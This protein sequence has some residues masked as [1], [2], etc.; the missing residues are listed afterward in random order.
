MLKVIGQK[1]NI[2][3][4]ATW[5]KIPNFIICEGERGSGRKTLLRHIAEQFGADSIVVG[6]KVDDIRDIILDANSLFNER[7]YVLEGDDM[8]PGA[9]NSLLK[10]T[11]EPP[12]RCHLALLVSSTQQTL[13][14]LVSR[15]HVM[16]TAPYTVE[17][18]I[19]YLKSRIELKDERHYVDYANMVSNLG[20]FEPLLAH[21]IS[22]VYQKVNDLYESI[23]IASES[24]ALNIANWLKLK[25]TGNDDAMEP[26]M[27]FKA[28]SNIGSIMTVR[29]AEVMSWDE[30]Y[31]HNRLLMSISKCIRK[32]QMKSTSKEITVNSWIREVKSI[33]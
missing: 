2:G 3:K 9:K 26:L 24:N 17:E 15:A 21:G 29:E 5:E 22:D 23:D 7:I 30:A 13:P 6:N 12:K 33:E 31:Y 1:N 28:L 25:A 32:L 11:E 8:S 14:T 27:F 10:I 18:R 4:V 16:T 19:E 20:E